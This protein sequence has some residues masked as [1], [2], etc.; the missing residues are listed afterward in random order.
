MSGFSPECSDVNAARVMAD[1]APLSQQKNDSCCLRQ[2]ALVPPIAWPLAALSPGPVVRNCRGAAIT[3]MPRSVPSALWSVPRVAV[4]G[5]RQWLRLTSGEVVAVGD[6]A[7]F[8][9]PASGGRGWSLAEVGAGHA[10]WGDHVPGVE[11]QFDELSVVGRGEADVAPGKCRAGAPGSGELL[12]L[13]GEQCFALVPGEGDPGN[14]IRSR[15]RIC[16]LRGGSRTICF[17]GPSDVRGRRPAPS[18]CQAS[19][20]SGE[21]AR[22]AS[23]APSRCGE[24]KQ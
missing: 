20:E 3:L 12:G 13:G 10:L 11:N 17:R 19:D 4:A 8:G 7:A 21:R 15:T 9:V 14:L 24:M 1:G 2:H 6:L 16:Q 22:L 23:V 5:C 18:S